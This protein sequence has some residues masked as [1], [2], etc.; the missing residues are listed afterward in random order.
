VAQP[1]FK[2]VS[3]M[4]DSELSVQFAQQLQ[5]QTSSK[6]VFQSQRERERM[7]RSRENTWLV[8]QR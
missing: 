6:I 2:R 8:V 1:S 5:R 7:I 3:T 4:K